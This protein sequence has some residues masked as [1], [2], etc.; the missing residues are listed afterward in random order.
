MI[1]NNSGKNVYIYRYQELVQ[2][3]LTALSTAEQTVASH[4]AAHP[5]QL[6][7]E[8]AGSLAKRLGVSSMTVGRTL[9]G[10]GYRG[11]ADIRTEMRLEVSDAAPWS[12]RGVFKSPPALK[13]ADRRRALN[14]ELEAIET[15][16]ALAESPTWLKAAQLIAGA[17]QVFVA[18]FQ[19]ERGLALAFADQLAYVRPRVRYLS[20]ED[21]AFADL[22]TE[23]CARS[24]IV[25]VDC[26]RYSRW[27]RVLGERAVALG[28]PL[29]IVT[30]AYCNWANDLTPYALLARTDSGRFWDNNAPILSLLN[31]LVEDVIEQLG[32]AVHSQLDGASEFGAAFVGF[33]RVHR[34]RRSKKGARASQ[35]PAIHRGASDEHKGARVKR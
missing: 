32:E 9:K 23:A 2:K 35:G 4:L 33:E 14:A 25:I 17:D 12:R 28:V 20:V 18:G 3:H 31:L 11:L 26:R 5:E 8:T 30:D 13:D 1:K 16:H 24:C 27:F 29:L 19:S 34:R 15:L 10:L 22:R 6:P 7:F 21:R